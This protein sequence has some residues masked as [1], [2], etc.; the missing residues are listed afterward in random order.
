VQRATAF[1]AGLTAAAV[2]LALAASSSLAA[3]GESSRRALAPEIALRHPS[4]SERTQAIYAAARRGDLAQVPILIERLDDDDPGVRLAAGQAL[5]RLTGHDTGYLA[6]EER[7]ER[8]RHVLA[9]RRWWAERNP[10]VGVSPP[11]APTPPGVAAPA[12]EVVR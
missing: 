7:P 2:A 4:P 5:T 9:W 6:F 11:F 10:T 12:P 8:R 1:P 3:C